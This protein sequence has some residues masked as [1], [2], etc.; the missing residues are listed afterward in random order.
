MQGSLARGS[1]RT[2]RLL[3]ST[4]FVVI[5][6]PIPGSAMKCEQHTDKNVSNP[7]SGTVEVYISENQRETLTTALPVQTQ[8]EQIKLNEFR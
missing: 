8:T 1:D 5:R 2:N 7:N 3:P 6:W 4:M